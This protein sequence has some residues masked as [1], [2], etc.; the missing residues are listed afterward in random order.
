[1]HHFHGAF[2]LEGCENLSSTLSPSKTWPISVHQFH[3]NLQRF[4]YRSTLRYVNKPCSHTQKVT[5]HFIIMFMQ[6]MFHLVGIRAARSAYEHCCGIAAK[7]EQGRFHQR[8][9]AVETSFPCLFHQHG[10]CHFLTHQTRSARIY[11][12][13]GSVRRCFRL[14]RCWTIAWN[15]G[16]PQS[17]PLI[18][19]SFV[20]VRHARMKIVVCTYGAHA[21]HAQSMPTHPLIIH[22]LI[23]SLF[24]FAI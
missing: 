23:P 13:S 9:N 20:Y 10:K 7:P 3:L 14:S 22:S 24:E 12:R 4:H 17:K 18:L 6:I 16:K 1:M 5:L 21:R 2:F 11:A 19:A 15:D 8:G